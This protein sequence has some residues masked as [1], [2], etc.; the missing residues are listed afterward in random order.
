MNARFS[1]PPDDQLYYCV[2]GSP[3]AHSKSPQIHQAFAKQFGIDLVY[4]RVEVKSGD[5]ASAL[6]SFRECGGRG[7][8]VT[9]PLKE[10]AFALGATSTERARV[11]GAANTVWFDEAGQIHTDNTDGVGLLRDLTV[12]RRLSLEGS[13]VLLLGAGGAAR[14]VMLP[15]LQ[16][17]LSELR[18]SNRSP[19]KAAALA[20]DFSIHGRVTVTPWGEVGSGP[21]D[22]VINATSMSLEGLVPPLGESALG[23][24]TSCYDMMYGSEPTAFVR[25]ALAAGC[26]ASDGL[27]MLVEQAAESFRIWHGCMPVTAPVIKSLRNELS[28]P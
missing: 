19:E 15:L 22:L 18:V 25:W 6:T 13:T 8:N 16:A 21:P 24:R 23:A 2:V 27:G 5:L 10:E 14:G 4:D 12:N 7:L 26:A 20:S 11:A 1:A 3:V 28:R 17:G 9:L